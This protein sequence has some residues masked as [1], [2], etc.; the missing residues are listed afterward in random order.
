MTDHVSGPPRY[1]VAGSIFIDDIVYPDGRTDMEIL[2]GGG[3]HAAAGVLVWGERAGLYSCVGQGLPE[4]ART[5]IWRDFD[6][7]GVVELPLP[8]ARAWQIFEWDGHRTEVFRM[9]VM[10][11]F[12]HDPQAPDATDAYDG[13]EAVYVLRDAQNLWRW[14]AR[15]PHAMMLWEPDQPYMVAEN[16][17]EYRETLP[18]VEIVSPNLVEARALYGIDDPVTLVRQ[19]LADGAKVAALRM[20]EDGSLGGTGDTV[21]HCPAVPVPKVVDVTGAGNTFCGGLMVG[22]MRTRD[23]G[24]ALAYGAVSG[25][26]AIEQVGVLDATLVDSAERDRRFAWA[27]DSVRPA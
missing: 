14:R 3:T 9:K 17:A 8:Q 11:P 15:H 7:R 4:S 13:A 18:M 5:R 24:Q 2:G 21:W 27:L 6:T 22:W 1:A 25:S 10:D 19:M 26:F 23:I 20:G 12:I 16:K